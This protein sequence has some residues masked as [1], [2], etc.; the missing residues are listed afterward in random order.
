MAK[1]PGVNR[2]SEETKNRIKDSRADGEKDVMAKKI[3]A[4][5]K[6]TFGEGGVT[7]ILEATSDEFVFA[8]AQDPRGMMS[9]LLLMLA[10]LMDKEML[11]DDSLIR[12]K[13]AA[14]AVEQTGSLRSCFWLM[15][16]AI[17]AE[18]KRF[19]IDFG[20]CLL[21]EI[22]DSTLFDRR[23]RDIAELLIFEPKMSAKEAVRELE[24]RGH[25]GTT[26]ENFRMRKMRL[27]KAKP[28]LNAVIKG[29][30]NELRAPTV[31]D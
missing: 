31:T 23:D 7:K 4:K 3:L 24:R 12:A 2:S 19:F 17:E 21:G 10:K 27:L 18:D 30:Y 11:K 26:E 28:A 29:M 6:C 14:K 9:S 8:M 13:L 25:V 22:K 15:Q 5:W 16:L 1:Q 20:K